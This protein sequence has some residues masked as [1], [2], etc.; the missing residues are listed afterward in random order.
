VPQEI[1][2]EGAAIS[3]IGI[4]K[5]EVTQLGVC[6]AKKCTPA[7]KASNV[8]MGFFITKEFCTYTKDVCCVGESYLRLLSVLVG[9]ISVLE[10]EAVM[11]FGLL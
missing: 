7:K 6:A 11:N 10:C 4:P 9:C 1:P 2:E 5:P 8:K 3:T